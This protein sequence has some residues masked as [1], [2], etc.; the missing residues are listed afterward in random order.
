MYQKSLKSVKPIT[1]P[2]ETH[3]L[4]RH[5]VCTYITGVGELSAPG[6]GSTEVEG[7]MSLW[8]GASGKAQEIDDLKRSADVE[9]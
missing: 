7:S 1:S 6:K 2:P 5:A 3:A 4:G 9:V 8:P